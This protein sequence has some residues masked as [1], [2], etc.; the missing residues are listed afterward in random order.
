[1]IT[2]NQS[3][4][5]LVIM[6]ML[7]LLGCKEEKPVVSEVTEV[8]QT[9]EWYELHQEVRKEVVAKC[10]DNPGQLDE[11]PNCNNAKTAELKSLTGKQRKV[12]GVWMLPDK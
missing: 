11:T 4:S 3:L 10:G 1:M 5:L 7:S 8:V 2:K 6:S 12:G 9:V